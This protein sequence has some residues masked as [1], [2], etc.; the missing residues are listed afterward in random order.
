M[1]IESKLVIVTN[2]GFLSNVAVVVVVVESK[3][4]HCISSFEA[5]RDASS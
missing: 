1:T 5:K 3:V 2:V 4:P